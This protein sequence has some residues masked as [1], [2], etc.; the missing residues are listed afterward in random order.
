MT[1]LR[2]IELVADSTTAA[3]YRATQSGRAVLARVASDERARVELR[4][5]HEVMT[6]I[7]SPHLLTADE[8]EETQFGLVALYPTDA[9][10]PLTAIELP[11]PLPAALRVVADACRGLVAL[12]A[13][14]WVHGGVQPAAVWVDLHTGRGRL[15]ELAA[16]FHASDPVGASDAPVGVP[17]YLSPEQS[18]RTNW[19]VDARSDLYSLGATAFA[20][21]VGRPPFEGD[22]AAVVHAHLAARPLFP[23]A[24]AALPQPMTAVLK[25]LLE[26]SPDERYPTA[27]AA[28]AAL[29]AA[30]RDVGVVLEPGRPP[31]RSSGVSLS[32]ARPMVRSESREHF[33]DTLDVL[34]ILTASQAIS[35]EISMPRLLDRL[36]ATVMESAGAELAV[37]AIEHRRGLCVEATRRVGEETTVFD[38]A[39]PA[40]DPR[41][42][43]SLI[44]LGLS[45]REPVLIDDAVTDPRTADSPCARRHG[46]RS[47]LALRL[48][49]QGAVVG[50]LV[51]VHTIAAGAFSARRVQFL[52]LLAAQFAISIHNARGYAR[53][54][55][56][57]RRRTAD[58]EEAKNAAEAADRAKSQFLAIVSHEIRTPLNAIVGMTSLLLET[59]L[60]PE[61]LDYARTIR[62]GSD[63]L[64][65]LINDLLDFSKIESGKLDFESTPFHLATCVEESIALV[66]GTG[67]E[68][69][70]RVSFSVDASVPATVIG[71]PTRVRQILVNLIANAVKFTP[72]GAIAVRVSLESAAEVD[73]ATVLRFEVTDTGIGIPADRIERLFLPFSQ[74]DASTT[75]HFGGT[76]LGLAIC[77]RLAE[78]MGGTVGVSSELGAGSTFW[79]TLPTHPADGDDDFAGF[80][81]TR[82]G[83]VVFDQRFATST[84]LRILVAEDNPVNQKLIGYMLQRL[85]YRCDTV[86]DGREVLRAVG[87]QPY[88][89]VL[90]DVQMPQMDGLEATRQLHT[91]FS[92]EARPYIIAV[93]ANTMSGDRERCLE[94]GM[95]AYLPKP[96]RADELKASLRRAAHFLRTRDVVETPASSGV[97]AEV[98]SATLTARPGALDHV[99]PAFVRAPTLD[100]GRLDSLERLGDATRVDVVGDLVRS[101]GVSASELVARAERAAASEDLTELEHAA[102][103]LR[104]AAANIGALHLAVLCEPIEA[105]ARDGRLPDAAAISALGS[106]CVEARAALDVWLSSR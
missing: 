10:R 65:S 4:R 37:V 9:G 3:A 61:Q 8:L 43:V 63:A 15:G 28:L 27:A 32:E 67:D 71:D 97:V 62:D 96:I 79:F 54:E 11:L 69:R 12:H 64:L 60:T 85:G 50:V 20:A 58:L 42:P 55:S 44:E 19:Q 101:F 36:L 1:A 41:F 77:R 34:S 31:T 17:A 100:L 102:H 45:E 35:S 7:G 86:G 66:T 33:G 95:D 82:T 99:P 26:K 52:R 39:L 18:G 68:K 87:R 94:A 104:G 47:A 56:L 49:H 5:E 75:R 6:S 13:A 103:K 93:T 51:L 83:T 78:A 73:D 81:R 23:V 89:V 30:A 76:G 38:P 24:P 16:A 22:D 105:G 91:R 46:V 21:L 90:M 53:L 2:L 25:R 59:A 29:E 57:V 74:V 70:L 88:D 84:P 80:G 98:A 48:E 40:T 72:E 92:H 14:G 106:A